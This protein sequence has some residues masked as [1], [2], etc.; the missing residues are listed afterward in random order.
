[1]WEGC[2]QKRKDGMRAPSGGWHGLHRPDVEPIL[3]IYMTSLSSF[4][5][6]RARPGGDLKRTRRS[7]TQLRRG[8]FVAK[9][10]ESQAGKGRRGSAGPGRAQDLRAGRIFIRFFPR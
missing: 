1:M 9:K 10:S 3:Y 4:G 6:R 7:S 8:S 2:H 5:R